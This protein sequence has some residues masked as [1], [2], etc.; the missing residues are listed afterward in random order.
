MFQKTP[1][2]CFS[3]PPS[4]RPL[5]RKRI[6]A[7]LPRINP[8]VRTFRPLHRQGF[9]ETLFS[10]EPSR[11]LSDF[12]SEN[13]A[14]PQKEFPVWDCP[15]SE[16]SPVPAPPPS[17]RSSPLWTDCKQEPLPHSGLLQKHPP[18][19]K[20]IAAGRQNPSTPACGMLLYFY[21]RPT[22]LSGSF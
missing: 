1:V 18:T 2:T 10:E 9:Q 5:F 4:L 22:P 19:R 16:D 15:E 8:T 21:P 20:P 3:A 14:P 13:A 6:R 7:F 12:Q 11:Y 17:Q